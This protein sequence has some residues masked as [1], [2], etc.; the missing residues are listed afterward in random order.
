MLTEIDQVVWPTEF[1]CTLVT[2]TLILPNFYNIAISVEPIDANAAN[3]GLGFRKLRHF[4]D[5]QLTN[6]I[7]VCQ[8]SPIVDTLHSYDTNIILLPVEPYDFFV[9]A[10]LYNKFLKI[11]EKY[12]HISQL[13]I[14]SVVGDRVQY[15][16]IDP[17]DCGL[18]LKG[19]YWWNMDSVNTGTGDTQTWEE[20]N[21]SDGPRFEPRIIK[22]GLSEK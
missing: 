1:G 13:S 15:S 18:E 4:V 2:D 6:S 19:E 5:E 11:T 3:I 10:I 12:F 20:L 9:G 16:I 17:E 14:D 7:I 21:I 22:G 8:D